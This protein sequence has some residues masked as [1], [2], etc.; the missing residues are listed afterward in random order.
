M[1]IRVFPDPA[2]ATHN[3]GQGGAVAADR[4]SACSFD[5]RAATD[6]WEAM[7]RVC[8]SSVTAWSS[9]VKGPFWPLRRTVQVGLPEWHMRR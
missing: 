1:A 8:S 3:T 6:G 2:G 4:W 5:N 7:A 9:R